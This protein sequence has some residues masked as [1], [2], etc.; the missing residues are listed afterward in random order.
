MDS[1]RRK[2]IAA[3]EEWLW[4]SDLSLLLR[5]GYYGITALG[6]ILGGLTD[7]NCSR[8][9]VLPKA[10]GLADRSYKAASSREAVGS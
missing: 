7:A 1:G 3:E 4:R 9:W 6:Q 2:S 10:G 5:A 8:L